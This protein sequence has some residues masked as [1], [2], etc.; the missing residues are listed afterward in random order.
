M[1][2]LFLEKDLFRFLAS[3]SN[4]AITWFRTEFGL[5]L[6]LH[7]IRVYHVILVKFKD[8][9][10]FNGDVLYQVIFKISNNTHLLLNHWR[11]KVLVLCVFSLLEKLPTSIQMV[12][13]L[14]YFLFGEY[15]FSVLLDDQLKFL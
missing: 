10:I 13:V 9:L 5:D 15:S 7:S 14:F 1:L 11:Y 12:S 4:R 8:L 2:L 6:H 3:E